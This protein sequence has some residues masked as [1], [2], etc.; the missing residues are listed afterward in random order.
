MPSP[1]ALRTQEIAAAKLREA[2]ATQKAPLPDPKVRRA[3]ARRFRDILS[4]VETGDEIHS[5]HVYSFT[6]PQNNRDAE[7][8]GRVSDSGPNNVCVGHWNSRQSRP[9]ERRQSRAYS[10]ARCS[11]VRISGRNSYR[12]FTSTLC[13]RKPSSRSATAAGVSGISNIAPP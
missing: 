3:V 13:R 10:T 11:D 7:P 6:A 9:P 5:P 8:V 12:E 2:L 4:F 1:A